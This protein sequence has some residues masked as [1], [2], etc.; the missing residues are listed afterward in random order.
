M[1]DVSFGW[2]DELRRR[3]FPPERNFLSAHLTLFHRLTPTQVD[4]LRFLKLPGAAVDLRFDRVVLLGS[5]VALHVQSAEIERLR[6]EIR[7]A[8]AGEF[9]RQDDQ[10]W[11]P[12]VTVQ[13]KASAESAR[14]LKRALEN[15]FT[16]R[17]GTA[18]GLLIWQYLGG[19][20]KLTQR[21]VFHSNAP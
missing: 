19:P 20:W 18:T 17:A 9:S 21:I 11:R 16:E 4:R 13:N 2:L 5:G 7:N 12:H 6:D 14:E 3:H 1:D 15:G 8:V 10:P